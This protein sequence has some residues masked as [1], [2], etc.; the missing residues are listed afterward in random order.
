MHRDR[1][2]NLPESKLTWQEFQRAGYDAVTFG[3]QEFQDWDLTQQW[4][5][6]NPIPV[7]C[8]NVEQLVE[9][10]WVPVG[11]KYLITSVNGVRTGIVSMITENQLLPSVIAKQNDTLRLLPPLEEVQRTV[12]LLRE[13]HQAE[14]VVLLGMV[15]N[16][17]MEQFATLLHGVDV[18]VG[19]YQTRMDDGPVKLGDTL[20]NR[21]GTRGQFVALTELIVSPQGTVVE[22]GGQNVT[23]DAKMREH[24]GVLELIKAAKQESTILMREAGRRER[25]E[26]QKAAEEQ[27]GA[28]KPAETPSVPA[29]PAGDKAPEA[30]APPSGSGRD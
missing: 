5:R 29:V 14:V 12:N 7:V 24:P 21:A 9:G 28:T 23:L 15:E 27:A 1:E 13:Q 6:E 18:M 8:T 4:M 11:Q 22:F 26:S 20:L 3:R 30:Q 2:R 25:E 17:A 10:Q 19:G 16:E